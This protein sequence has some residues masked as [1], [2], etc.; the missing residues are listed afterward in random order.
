M[1]IPVLSY[2]SINNESSSVSLSTKEFENQLIYLKKN[3]YKS[4]FYDDIDMS[5]DKQIIIT[6]D[7]GYKDIF[8]NCLPLLKKYE[9]KAICYIVV[10][11]I[12]KTNEWD[13]DNN[14]VSK[15]ELM[16]NENL[17]EWIKNEMLIGSHSHDHFDLT[18]LTEKNIIYQLEKSKIQLE[19]MFSTKISSFCYPYGKYNLMIYK[20]AKNIYENAV[21]T[22]RSRYNLD[23]HSK[24]LIPRIDM[25]KKLSKFKLYLK[26][27]TIYEDIKYNELQLR[28]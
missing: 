25:G 8:L 18:K 21:T 22:N 11:K 20:K 27:Q 17:N 2:H 16:S 26:L 28:L 5:K 10:N 6:F 14:S 12:G 24:H 7:D 19:D 1:K 3:N 23:K 9:F 13:N 4:V 15:K